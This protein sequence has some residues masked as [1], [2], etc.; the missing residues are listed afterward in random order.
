MVT[1]VTH[2]TCYEYFGKKS[3]AKPVRGVGNGSI[4]HEMDT[5]KVFLFDAEH[6][7]WLEQ[8]K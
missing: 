5:G 7:V 6:K 4:Y 8:K 3:D 1:T 2:E